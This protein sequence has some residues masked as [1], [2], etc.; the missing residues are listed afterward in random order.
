MTHLAQKQHTKESWNCVKM[1]PEQKWTACSGSKGTIY[2]PWDSLF[3]PL[4]SS[5]VEMDSY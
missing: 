2:S 3:M 4:V 1:G 5:S